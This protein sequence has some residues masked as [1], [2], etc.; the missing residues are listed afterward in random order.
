MCTSHIPRDNSPALWSCGLWAVPTQTRLRH[1]TQTTI[2]RALLCMY[3]L[4][5]LYTVQCT[6]YSVRRTVFSE[7]CSVNSVQCIMTFV[8]NIHGCPI[9]K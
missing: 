4:R 3:S 1:Y 8:Y 2:Y 5:I 9:Y 6:V 7:L